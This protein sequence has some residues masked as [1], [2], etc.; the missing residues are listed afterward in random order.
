MDAYNRAVGS[1]EARV[2]PQAR[3]FEELAAAPEGLELPELA[4]VESL[5][6][7]LVAPELASVGGR[8]ASAR[9]SPEEE[10]TG[11]L[12]LTRPR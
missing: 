12:A 2:L 9:A 10:R 8:S 5:P 1:L 11:E 6:R 3:R 4:P 7:P